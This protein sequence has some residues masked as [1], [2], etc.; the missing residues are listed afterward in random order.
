MIVT[1]DENILVYDVGKRMLQWEICYEQ[2]DS[3]NTVRG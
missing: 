1:K 3:C 2:S